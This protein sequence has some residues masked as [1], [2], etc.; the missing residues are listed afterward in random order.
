MEDSFEWKW[1]ERKALELVFRF[2]KTG[3]IVLTQEEIEDIRSWNGHYNIFMS[4]FNEGLLNLVY[5]E[6]NRTKAR[7][8][9]SKKLANIN[10]SVQEKPTGILYFLGMKK[11]KSVINK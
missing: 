6:K 9:I 11:G 4:A 2:N 10:M 7:Q 3:D 5:K 8:L 1:M